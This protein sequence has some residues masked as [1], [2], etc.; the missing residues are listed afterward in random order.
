MATFNRSNII[1]HAIDSVRRQ[2]WTDWEL[3][4]VGDGCTDDTAAVVEAFAD[5]RVRFWN[6]DAPVGEQSGPNN[7]GLA[8]A[9]GRIIAFLNHDDLWAPRHLERALAVLDG[10]PAVDLVFGL[11]VA[12]QP[13]GTFRVKGATR[14]GGYDPQAGVPA[15]GWVFRRGLVDRVGPWRAARDLFDQPSQ[16]WLR[17]AHR[18]GAR[19][20]LSRRVAVVS[21]PSGNRPG[22]YARRE[23]EEH[24]HWAARMTAHE[25]WESELLSEVVCE[26][27][28]TSYLSSGTLAVWPHVKRAML[29][30]ARR[31]IAALGLPANAVWFAL[32]Y[33][34]RGGFL[35]R[36]RRVRGLAPMPRRH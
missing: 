30:G 24:A 10:D 29:N 7:A 8:A 12:V 31:P 19:M 27:D 14:S 9:R 36:L 16:E 6:L 25:D 11:N 13:N 17:R 5:P 1:G 32:A 15:S 26:L 18:A 33:R 3:L 22:S 20:A 35:D 2:T 34:R 23:C 4:V 21:L 28:A